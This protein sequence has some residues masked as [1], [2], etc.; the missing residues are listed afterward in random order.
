MNIVKSKERANFP[1]LVERR[2]TENWSTS[3][4]FLEEAPAVAYAEQMEK[5]YPRVPW[6]VLHCTGGPMGERA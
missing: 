6:R 3:K 4:A 2:N 5:L 1:Y